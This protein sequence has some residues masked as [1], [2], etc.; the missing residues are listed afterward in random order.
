VSIHAASH[1]MIG[2]PQDRAD[3]TVCSLLGHAN[4][5]ITLTTYADEW[6]AK[7]DQNTAVDIADVL[8]GSKTVAPDENEQS[9]G[10]QNPEKSLENLGTWNGGPCRSR[11][12]DQEIKSLL[13]IKSADIGAGTNSPAHAPENAATLSLSAYPKPAFRAR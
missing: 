10:A 4:P 11:T 5:Q 3:Q 9:G 12:Y 2:T 8:F 6:A 13:L 7:L 1:D